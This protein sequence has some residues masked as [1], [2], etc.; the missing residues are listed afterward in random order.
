MLT[1]IAAYI[2]ISS[3]R[4][5]ATHDVAI[6]DMDASA[7]MYVGEVLNI[8]V[9][10]RNKG[11][12]PETF[13]VTAYYNSTAIEMRT[14]VDLSPNTEMNLTYH[15]NTTQ[16]SPANYVMKAEAS[17]VAGETNTS[18]NAHLDGLVALRYRPTG[19]PIIYVDPVASLG[20]VGEIITVRLNVSEAVDLYGY[21]LKLRWNSTILEV[22]NVDEGSFLGS[23]G[24]TVFFPQMNSTSGDITVNTSLLDNIPGAAG[25]GT[26]IT[27]QF[28]VK[29]AGSCA[30]DLYESQLISSLEQTI[31]HQ[32]EDGTFE[33]S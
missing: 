10:V 27:I 15:W 26:L 33:T 6:T 25:N 32:A 24:P 11:T 13:N 9:T 1:I 2:I 17:T 14:I 8:T 30:L 31:S 4:V 29:E 18:D 16:L 19:Q 21:G 12:K 22:V 20:S 28:R 7:E 23:K 3:S 5:A